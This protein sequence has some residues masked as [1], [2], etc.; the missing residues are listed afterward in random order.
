GVSFDRILIQCD[1]DVEVIAVR[2]DLLFTGA[3]AQ[4]DVASAN[5]RL[6]A[7]VSAQVKPKTAAGFG[8][9][10]ARLV[11]PVSGGAGD[12]DSDLFT[13]VHRWLLLKHPRTDEF[14]SHYV[15]SFHCFR[16]SHAA[17]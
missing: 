16:S 3:H 17:T 11:Q 4:P 7:V 12:A 10:V 5:H 9:G 15:A 14:I 8:D 13:L 1:Q 2:V 6:I